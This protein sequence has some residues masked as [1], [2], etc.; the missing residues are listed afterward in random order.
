ME[1]TELATLM[2]ISIATFTAGLL[3]IC[4]PFSTAKPSWP[5]RAPFLGGGA[6]DTHAW[7]RF[8]V[9]YYPMTLLLIAFEMEM[10]FM[11]PWAVVY[12]E[13]GVKALVEM[14][15]FLAILSVGIVYG[16]RE[17]AFKWQ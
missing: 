5:Q 7:S 9:R 14:G 16:W 6:P 15:M 3:V 2:T 17:G 4:S 8:H 10:M 12:V 11:Y 13:E 1:L